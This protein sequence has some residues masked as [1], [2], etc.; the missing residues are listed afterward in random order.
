MSAQLDFHLTINRAA[1]LARDAT[2]A[3]RAAGYGRL[4]APHRRILNRAIY[5]LESA[6]A[7]LIQA[8]DDPWATPPPKRQLSML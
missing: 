7:E 2:V 4:P 3:A 6:Q 8:R 5:K 1:D